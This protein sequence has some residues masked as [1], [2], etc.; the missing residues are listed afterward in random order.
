MGKVKYT[1]DPAGL[2]EIAQSSG[3]QAAALDAART[4][5]AVARADDPR[6][7]YAERPAT[8]TGGWANERRAGATVDETRRGDGARKRSLARAAGARR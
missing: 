1:P 7:D 8:V 2:R 5:S 6:G 4:V 3:V